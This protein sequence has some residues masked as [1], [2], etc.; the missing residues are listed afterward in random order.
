MTPGELLLA[1]RKTMHEFIENNPLEYN[2]LVSSTGSKITS[3]SNDGIYIMNPKIHYDI[4]I[5]I[6]CFENLNYI[7]FSVIPDMASH[8]PISWYFTDKNI[9][10]NKIILKFAPHT[11]L[12][13]YMDNC[14][15]DIA[16][17][18][19]NLSF[20]KDTLCWILSN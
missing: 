6:D 18:F 13:Q 2:E 1:F 16:H 17:N 20:N 4:S 14:I 19:F 9:N 10:D 8:H 12:T 15:L 5:K 3:E 7:L 11:H